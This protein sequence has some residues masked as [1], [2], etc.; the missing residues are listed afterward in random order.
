MVARACARRHLAETRE[1]VPSVQSRGHGRALAI[2][3]RPA[4][5]A[6]SDR[7][8]SARRAEA[9][10]EG[11]GAPVR[12]ARRRWPGEHRRTFRIRQSS[13]GRRSVRSTG[14]RGATGATAPRLGESRPLDIG[15]P[16]LALGSSRCARFDAAAPP[17]R[18]S[19]LSQLCR[20][21]TRRVEIGHR[22]RAD[23]ESLSR[24]SSRHGGSHHPGA[25]RRHALARP[26]RATRPLWMKAGHRRAPLL[27]SLLPAVSPWGYPRLCPHASG[28]H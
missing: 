6:P 11:A 17:A 28:Q 9:D 20:N 4:R 13:S 21:C 27:S 8:A 25:T 23:A 15:R 2:G 26:G 12:Q 5:R 7:R 14:S 24:S 22:P 1:G 19:R 3:T 10:R 16:S 18:Q